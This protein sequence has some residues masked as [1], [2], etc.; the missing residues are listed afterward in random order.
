MTAPAD[1]YAEQAAAE[2]WL[3]DQTDDWPDADS[4]RHMLRRGRWL[5]IDDLN[6]IDHYQPAT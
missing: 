2:E 5:P 6:D 1:Y 4:R 3:A